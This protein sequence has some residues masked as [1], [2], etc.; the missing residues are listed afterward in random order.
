[1][2]PAIPRRIISGSAQIDGV[3]PTMS[4]ARIPSTLVMSVGPDSAEKIATAIQDKDVHERALVISHRRGRLFLSLRQRAEIDLGG[5]SGAGQ[6]GVT[7]TRS[8][9]SLPS[10]MIPSPSNCI[11]HRKATKTRTA[12]IQVLA[13]P[14]AKNGYVS[15]GVFIFSQLTNI[16]LLLASC[17][18]D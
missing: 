11:V 7:L 6:R 15:N 13:G 8:Q 14:F 1:M 9:H 17:A 12:S 16:L 4:L 5:V 18:E 10:L 3:A 2:F